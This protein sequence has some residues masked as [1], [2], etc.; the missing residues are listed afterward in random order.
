MQRNDALVRADRRIEDALFDP[1]A[2]DWLK[3]AL[4]AQ[5]RRDPI[6]A[7]AD[8]AMLQQLLAAR[9][10][11]ILA[12]DQRLAEVPQLPFDLLL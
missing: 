8:A 7:V 6:D 4:R 2:S 11:A 12:A 10:D 9:C 1:A 5:L 3:A